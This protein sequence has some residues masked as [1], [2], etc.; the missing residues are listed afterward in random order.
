MT[1]PKATTNLNYLKNLHPLKVL[2]QYGDRNSGELEDGRIVHREKQ[3]YMGKE[4]GLVATAQTSSHFIYSDPDLNQETGQW[5]TDRN[6]NPIR[7]FV[8]R[9][10]PMCS[11]G[12]PAV[13]TGA[14]V[15]GNYASPTGRSESTTPGMMIVCYH[16]MTFGVHADGS[17][18]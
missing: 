7:K 12:S 1:E 16:L 4:Y 6:G 8:G 18:N 15:Y 3:I 2:K 10:S 9:W 11:C 14:N 5:P 13:V 17:H